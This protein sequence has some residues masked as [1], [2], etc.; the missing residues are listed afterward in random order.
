M[1][2]VYVSGPYTNGDPCENTHRAIMAGNQLLDAGLIPF[3]PHVSHFWHTMTPRPWEDWMKI[4]LA[5]LPA[6]D[7]FL[8]L[9]GESK[10]A[11]IEEAEAVRLGMP[12]CRSI[13]EVF[14]GAGVKVNGFTV[15]R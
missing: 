15:H 11:D 2:K 1:K 8:R 6:C 7:I 10:G 5:F 9:P 12:I 14:A 3:V 13:M 4:D